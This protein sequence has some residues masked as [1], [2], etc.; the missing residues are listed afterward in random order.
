MKMIHFLMWWS[1]GSFSHGQIRRFPV[2]HSCMECGKVSVIIKVATHF[3][4]E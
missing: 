2:E 4:F 3:E 1:I